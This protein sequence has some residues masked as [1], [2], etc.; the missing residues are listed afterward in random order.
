MKNIRIAINPILKRRHGPEIHWTWRTL[1]S[2]IGS[3]WEE[4]PIDSECDIAYVSNPALVPSARLCIQADPG[5]WAQPATFKLGRIGRYNGLTYPTFEDETALSSIVQRAEGRLVCE[6][7]LIFAVFWLATGQEE[8]YW[9][10]DQHGFFDL[11]GTTTLQEQVLPQALASQISCWL[12]QTL[13]ELGYPP[14]QPRWPHGKRAA[15]A[16]GHDV[17]YPQVKRLIEPLRILV[18]RKQRGLSPA[19]EVL[20]GRRHHWQFPA[21]VELEK[22]LQTRSAFY[23]VPR[24]GSLLEYATGTPDPFYDVASKPFRELFRYLRGEGFE[25]GLHA[26]YLAYQSREKFAAEKQRLEEA[27][28]RPVVGNRHHYWHLNPDNV[29]ETLL[30]HEQIG[31]KYDASLIHEN[32]LGWRRGLSQPFFPFYQAQRRELKTLQLSTAWMDDHLFGHREDNSGDRFELLKALADRAAEQRGCLLIDIHEYVFDDKLFP[33]W[34]QCYRQLWEYLLDRGDFWFATPAQI[35][36]HWTARY[37]DLVQASQ[38]LNE[39]MA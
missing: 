7:D 24:Q 21:W 10:K 31:L 26:S 3:T 16:V 2:G 12:E 17:D 37:A 4:V 22:Q 20:A 32:Y 5:A 39:G 1:L 38:G 23:F 8:R 28:N 33:G 14:G 27:T 13:Y 15:A 34:R 9:P 19:L 36:A 35:A 18:R 30:I 11:S 25:V 6:R 29:E